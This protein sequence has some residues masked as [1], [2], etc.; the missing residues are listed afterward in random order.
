MYIIFESGAYKY[1][2]RE[3][4][5]NS[6]PKNIICDKYCELDFYKVAVE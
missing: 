5:D 6:T 1:D 3:D 2:G 4:K